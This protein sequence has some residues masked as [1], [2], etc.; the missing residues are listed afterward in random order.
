MM[1]DKITIAIPV[2]NRFDYFPEALQS[3]LNQ[4]VKCRI[5]VV[6]NNSDHSKFED[7]ISNLNNP[8]IEYYRN[9]VN[10]GMAGNFNKCI[11][12]AQTEWMTILHDDDLLHP[13]FIE[14]TLSVSNHDNEIGFIAVKTHVGKSIG[15]TFER[16]SYNSI[17]FRYIKP[18][19][20]LFKNISP[21]PGI[22]FKK[23]IAQKVGVFENKEFPILDLTFWYRI[24]REVKSALIL[25]DLAFYRVSHF[26][27]T[28]TNINSLIDSTLEFR[29][30]V[31]NHHY[32]NNP[33]VRHLIK[34]GMTDLI[35][36]Y[37][38]TYP[39]TFQ[40]HDSQIKIDKLTD[41]RVFNKVTRTIEDKMS[42]SRRFEISPG[43][44]Y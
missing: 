6:D 19:L 14:K 44:S 17:K 38:K 41:N 13:R 7:Y 33:I 8:S 35:T 11:E 25:E 9:E 26:Q 28:N 21:F 43:I 23:H 39:G 34:K 18:T 30:K 37:Q 3:A 32:S 15:N 2:Y 42:F 4:T 24:V 5:I 29:E 1:T 10:E 31:Y 27:E 20:F 40:Y 16:P 22:T 36:Y 12:F